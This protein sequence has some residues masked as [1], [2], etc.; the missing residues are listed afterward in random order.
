MQNASAQ[1]APAAIQEHFSR[2]LEG[3]PSVGSTEHR[4]P[5]NLSTGS[6]SRWSVPQ[7]ATPTSAATRS[8]HPYAETPVV[9]QF[10]PAPPPM[11]GTS[12]PLQ[13]QNFHGQGH[14][15]HGAFW[16]APASEANNNNFAESY[17]KLVADKTTEH[18][19]SWVE[20]RRYFPSAFTLACIF[21][22][23]NPIWITAHLGG[24]RTVLYWF[25]PWCRTA[26]FLP[27]I[28]I[29]GHV[30]HFK[31]GGPYKPVVLMCLLVPSVYL[32]VLNDT[33]MANAANKADQLFST[34][35]GSFDGKRQLETSWTMARD[36]YVQCLKDT[37]RLA[38]AT[39]NLTFSVAAKL[40]RFQDCT[41]F[42]EEKRY[43][44]DWEYLSYLE[45][46]EACGGWCTQSYPL[47]TFKDVRDSCSV[48]AA[49][50]FDNKIAKRSRQALLYS[51]GALVCTSVLMVAA[52]PFLRARG[53]EW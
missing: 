15:M 2:I 41:E 4:S 9:A 52:G 46:E 20:W 11:L 19:L 29:F 26:I 37:V 8:P 39:R 16:G 21:A 24:D 1:D 17:D 35:C 50:I 27:L 53:Y 25:G 30:V 48:A 49:Q 23:L 13:S 36:L 44:A 33:T 7:E 38:P 22:F 45:E 43:R 32:L 51:L 6:L 42:A 12:L 14:P 5:L 10:R 28:F 34:D 18:M 47:W 3:R 40:Y 31:R